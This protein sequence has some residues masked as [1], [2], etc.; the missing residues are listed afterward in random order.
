M[1]PAP[2]SSEDPHLGLATEH[3]L[4]IGGQD[5]GLLARH[6]VRLS[7]D[8]PLAIEEEHPQQLAGG[9]KQMHRDDADLAGAA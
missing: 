1:P 7:G 4:L 5:Q 2:G 6:V 9:I 8:V 3:P